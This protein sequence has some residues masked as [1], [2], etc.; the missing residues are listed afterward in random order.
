[1]TKELGQVTA[2]LAEDQALGP[3]EVSALIDRLQK[4]RFAAH[5]G[6]HFSVLPL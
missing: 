1:V 4:L 2:A 6:H 3:D 5:D